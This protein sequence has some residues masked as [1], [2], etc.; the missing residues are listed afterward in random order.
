[1]NISKI[2]AKILYPVVKELVIL[3]N[4]EHPI[5]V[6]ISVSTDKFVCNYDMRR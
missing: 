2:I 1:M 4:L 6:G 3:Y 5:D